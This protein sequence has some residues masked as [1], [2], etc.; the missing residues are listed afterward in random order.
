MSHTFNS[1]IYEGGGKGLI[2]EL[3][4]KN[5]AGDVGKLIYK[6]E[7]IFTKQDKEG[8][9]QG[10]KKVGRNEAHPDERNPLRSGKR[11]TRESKS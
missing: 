5:L 7:V 1:H 4:K 11:K 8:H 10:N 9:N 6:L 3:K 2:D